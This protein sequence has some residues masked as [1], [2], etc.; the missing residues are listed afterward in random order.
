MR[1]CSM[2]LLIAIFISK[3]SFAQTSSSTFKRFGVIVGGNVSNMNFNKGI[4]PPP[5][6]I[7]AAWK[8][9]ITAGFSLQIPLRNKLS[10]QTEYLYSQVNAEDKSTEIKYFLNYL[11]MPVLLK[12]QL[13]SNIAVIAGPQA[14]LLITA[15]KKSVGTSSNMTHDTE[16]RSFGLA[17]GLEFKVIKDASLNARYVYGL[18]HIGIGQRSAVK[19]FKLEQFQLTV[20]VKF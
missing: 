13:Y 4:P 20:S 16:E 15:K 1:L 7:K 11:S 10:I 9:A 18:N 19:E 17:A 3:L 14:G 12:Y 6:V 8:A 5:V 2:L